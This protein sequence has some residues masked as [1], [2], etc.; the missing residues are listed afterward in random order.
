MASVVEVTAELNDGQLLAG[1]VAYYGPRPSGQAA[2]AHAEHALA[3]VAEDDEIATLR[4]AGLRDAEERMRSALEALV[5]AFLLDRV[6]NADCFTLAH[7]L[8]ASI[9]RQFSCQWTLTDSGL[10]LENRCGVLALHSR[11]GLSPGGRS[12]GR[13]SICS[14]EDFRCDHLVGQ[15][16]AGKRCVREVYRFDTEEVSV[17]P[18]PR[19][20]RCFRT[21]VPVRLTDLPQPMLSCQHCRRCPGRSGPRAEDLDQSLWPTDPDSL[22]AVNARVARWAGVSE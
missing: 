3:S 21:W 10:M 12:W 11:V 5:D 13:C 18:A 8:G 22:L 6:N 19:E 14:A 2:R 15:F 9:E 20:P 7:R 1:R 4:G 17:T 16:Y